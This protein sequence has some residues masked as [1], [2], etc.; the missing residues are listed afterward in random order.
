MRRNC[1]QK[2][3][4]TLKL[5]QKKDKGKDDNTTAKKRQRTSSQVKNLK[6]RIKLKSKEK[7]MPIESYFRKSR[8]K[9]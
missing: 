5:S 2:L 8:S 9:K 6:A 3:K 4:G 1:S 7:E